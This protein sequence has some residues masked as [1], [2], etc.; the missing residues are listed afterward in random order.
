M[1]VNCVVVAISAAAITSNTI[2]TVIERRAT[3]YLVATSVT[4]I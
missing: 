1:I 4:N 3:G 2:G